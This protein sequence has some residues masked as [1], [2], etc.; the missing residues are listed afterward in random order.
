MRHHKDPSGRQPKQKTPTSPAT[1]TSTGALHPIRALHPL[2]GGAPEQKRCNAYSSGALPQQTRTNA[3]LAHRTT[4]R[5]TPPWAAGPYWRQDGHAAHAAHAATCTP[6]HS[7]PIRHL[8]HP[9]MRRAGFRV[10]PVGRRSRGD[11]EGPQDADVAELAREVT[12]IPEGKRAER[13]RQPLQLDIR[14][15][16][17][18]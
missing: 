14:S 17:A 11:V 18:V 1:T 5:R 16:T 4:H 15:A 9:Y 7:G 6:A 12:V 8:L 13:V 3:E 10:R 2:R